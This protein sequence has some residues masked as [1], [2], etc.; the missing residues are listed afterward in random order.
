MLIDMKK[1]IVS[2]VTFITL[3]YSGNFAFAQNLTDGDTSNDVCLNLQTS[4]LRFRSNDMGTNGEVSLLQ[5]F[6][7]DKGYLSGSPTGFYGRLTV[8]AVKSYQREIGVS[9]T[10][11]VGPLTKSILMR[12]T[13]DGYQPLPVPVVISPGNGVKSFTFYKV[14]DDK[15]SCRITYFV[16]N[17]GLV[18]G[19]YVYK[20]GEYATEAE[21]MSS[22]S[23]QP[24]TQAL[25]Q[26]WIPEL[27]GG[28][29]LS[30]GKSATATWTSSENSRAASYSVYLEKIKGN[31]DSRIYVGTAYEYN[32]PFNFTVPSTIAAGTYA[33]V[34]NGKGGL[35]GS[36]QMFEVVSSNGGGINISS[37]TLDNISSTQINLNLRGS[38]F[39][40]GA[41]LYLN[42]CVSGSEWSFSGNS[43]TETGTGYDKKF[44]LDCAPANSYANV[45]MVGVDGSKSNV[46]SVFV[47][48]A[49]A[50]E[51]PVPA[52]V[53]T[54]VSLD[55]NQGKVIVRGTSLRNVTSL[56][57]VPVEKGFDGVLTKVLSSSETEA[58]FG[59][60]IN[61]GNAQLLG[62]YQFN[63]SRNDVKSNFVTYSPSVIGTFTINGESAEYTTSYG[64]AVVVYNVT[65][66]VISWTSS[67]ADYCAAESFDLVTGA[68]TS[69]F[70]GRKA[71]SGYSY[72]NMGDSYVNQRRITLTCYNKDGLPSNKKIGI[73]GGKG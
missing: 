41:N 13:C 49:F 73:V 50:A 44:F 19:I 67:N 37:A 8:N 14:S 45:Y 31:N 10:G 9:P 66:P 57:Y 59:M 22:L 28:N 11:N 1:Y 35:G 65:N 25:F 70:V 26:V 62:M 6:L 40:K 24:Q 63:V 27:K 17:V 58:V 4:V 69:D 54:S 42:G 72:L 52:P 15:K 56:L 48:G 47:P 5:D 46:V 34:F 16:G 60:D 43:D 38:G 20:S 64:N 18:N 2:L 51:V 53:V 39:K 3:F 61:L 71:V 7:I 23:Q 30:M 32:Q 33:L 29:S 21:C 68:A 55:M 12:E 36:S